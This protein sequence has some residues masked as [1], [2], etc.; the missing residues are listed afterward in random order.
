MAGGDGKALSLLYGEDGRHIYG[1]AVSSD[2]K[3]VIFTRSLTDG[4]EDTA[5]IA[6]MRLG[7]APTIGGESKALRKMHPKTKDGPVL[8]LGPGWEPH[9]TNAKIPGGGK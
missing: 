4:N 1:G 2:G 3:Y 8:L 9:W 6:L 7:D 5:E